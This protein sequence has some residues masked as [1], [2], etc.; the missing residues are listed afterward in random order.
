MCH[1]LRDSGRGPP[2]TLDNTWHVA[3]L[4]AGTKARYR[5]RIAISAYSTCIRRPRQGGSRRVLLYRFECKNQHDVA[6]RRS[7]KF[8]DMFIRFDTTHERDIHTDTHTHRDR[9][10]ERERDTA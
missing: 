1:N 9:E 5:L 4:T 3:A 10:R 7:K 8:D 6:T 2:A